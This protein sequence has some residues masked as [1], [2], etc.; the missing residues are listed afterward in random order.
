[1][2]CQLGSAQIVSQLQLCKFCWLGMC[3]GMG[4]QALHWWCTSKSPFALT[5][6]R[7]AGARPLCNEWDCPLGSCH[8]AVHVRAA[9]IPCM[10]HLCIFFYNQHRIGIQL[11]T[12][13]RP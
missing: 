11:S 4:L 3:V 8:S 12:V 6:C 9:G 10:Q 2:P 5:P 13:T 7:I 1:M